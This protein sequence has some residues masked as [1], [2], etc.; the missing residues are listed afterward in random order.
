MPE[1]ENELV[2]PSRCATCKHWDKRFPDNQMLGVCRRM[3]ISNWTGSDLP[4]RA[5]VS[6]ST[7]I[8][9][10]KEHAMDFDVS[11][12][13]EKFG[14]VLHSDYVRTQIDGTC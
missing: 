2:R 10:G 8:Q 12:T 9:H 1:S 14:C 3:T 7:H 13:N 5:H 6:V 11:T 4:S